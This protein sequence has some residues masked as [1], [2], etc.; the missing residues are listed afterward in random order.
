MMERT[1]DAKFIILQLI[2]T[3]II[4]LTGQ[5]NSLWKYESSIGVV[6]NYFDLG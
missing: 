6:M 5:G 3:E 2:K 1:Y 4:E